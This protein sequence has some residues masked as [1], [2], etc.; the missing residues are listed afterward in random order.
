MQKKWLLWRQIPG[1]SVCMRD[2]THQNSICTVR[3]QSIPNNWEVKA[4]KSSTI[5]LLTI[6][7]EVMVWYLNGY[8]WLKLGLEWPAGS[9]VMP[10]QT[11]GNNLICILISLLT[12][13]M[14]RLFTYKIVRTF[15]WIC[16][17]LPIRMGRYHGI[18]WPIL[19]IPLS[20]ALCFSR[21]SIEEYLRWKAIGLP[22]SRC[23]N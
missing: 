1:H 22:G 7:K 8:E 2:L 15:Q 11:E 20:C 12:L 3:E 14:N 23:P 19:V 16:K 21:H 4:S 6:I 13:H 10:C 18:P 5:S 17:N 9:A